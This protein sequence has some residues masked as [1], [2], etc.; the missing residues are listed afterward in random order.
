MAT[1]EP[2]DILMR[3]KNFSLEVIRLLGKLPRNN[4]FYETIGRQLLRSATSV[5]ANIIEAQAGSSRKDFANFMNYA[6]KSSNETR[7]W[8]EILRDSGKVHGP[9]I[10]DL[11]NEVIELGKILGA[12]M[13]RLRGKKF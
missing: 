3:S 1:H 11:I 9:L 5:G 12:S 13:I 4:Y 6:L 8:L 10:D 7:Y 2:K